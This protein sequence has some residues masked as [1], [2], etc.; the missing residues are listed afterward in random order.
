MHLMS[1]SDPVVQNHRRTIL[2]LKTALKLAK[3]EIVSQNAE[4]IRLKTLLNQ[5]YGEMSCK[6]FNSET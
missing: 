6:K 4:I 1:S 3:R 2:K 5:S